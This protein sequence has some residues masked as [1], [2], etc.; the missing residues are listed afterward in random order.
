MQIISISKINFFPIGTKY[1]VWGQPTFIDVGCSHHTLEKY[2]ANYFDFK[3]IFFSL[4]YKLHT[5]LNKCRLL[6][7]TELHVPYLRILQ[8]EDRRKL[9]STPTPPVGSQH[10]CQPTVKLHVYYPYYGFLLCERGSMGAQGAAAEICLAAAWGAASSNPDSTASTSPNAAL[11]T[12]GIAP[13]RPGSRVMMRVLPTKKILHPPRK[14]QHLRLHFTLGGKIGT[15]ATFSF[16]YHMDKL[17]F[18]AG[19]FVFSAPR[20]SGNKQV[21]Q[22]CHKRVGGAIADLWG[23]QKKKKCCCC[24]DFFTS[25]SDRV[26]DSPGH[27]C[28]YQTLRS[29]SVVPL[30]RSR[31]RGLTPS[32]SASAESKT[33]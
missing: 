20:C 2:F 33:P 23:P 26:V 3:N 18:L 6:T 5:F 21:R 15:T 9:Q 10:S 19:R 14:S 7:E 8:L 13:H 16:F 29:R 25:C 22:K 12:N 32:C 17:F 4:Q 31:A 28:N 24:S 1:T 27:A 30:T 11:H